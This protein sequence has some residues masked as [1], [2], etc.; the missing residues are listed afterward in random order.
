[1]TSPGPT[2]RPG[3]LWRAPGF[4]FL[5]LSLLVAGVAVILFVVVAGIVLAILQIGTDDRV[6]A[7]VLLGC[8]CVSITT[9]TVMYRLRRSRQPHSIE[10]QSAFPP[11]RVEPTMGETASPPSPLPPAEYGWYYISRGQK[12]GPAS[13]EQINL[14]TGSGTVDHDT[15][16]W[17]HGMKEWVRYK[18]SALQEHSSLTAVPPFIPSESVSNAWVWLTAFMPLCLYCLAYSTPTTR[19]ADLPAFRVMRRSSGPPLPA[20]TI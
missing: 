16:V 17:R 7:L 12:I 9:L 6:S 19:H 1:M 2:G 18:D 11:R 5:F 8:L 4:V 13:V 10:V 15:Y 14:L 3:Y 20:F